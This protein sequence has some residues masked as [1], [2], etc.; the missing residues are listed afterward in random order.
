MAQ[1]IMFI[2]IAT[3]SVLWFTLLIQALMDKKKED[4]DDD[5]TG[6]SL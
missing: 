3:G 6:Q 4:K 5:D 2:L 1:K